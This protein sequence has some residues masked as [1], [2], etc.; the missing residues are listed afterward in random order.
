MAIDDLNSVN[1]LDRFYV[2]LREI[3]I[4]A[5]VETRM[6]CFLLPRPSP[7]RVIDV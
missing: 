4:F 2:P 5:V 7:R 3:S 1:G 6:V